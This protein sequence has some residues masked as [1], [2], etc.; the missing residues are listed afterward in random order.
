MRSPSI[1][2]R[3]T[4]PGPGALSRVT[5]AHFPATPRPTVCRCGL[6]RRTAWA[7]VLL[8]QRLHPPGGPSRR[9]A[10]RGGPRQALA[11]AGIASIEGGVYTVTP[12]FGVIGPIRESVAVLPPPRS[13]PCCCRVAR[14]LAGQLV[15]HDS[16]WRPRKPRLAKHW[17]VGWRSTA[18]VILGARL[19][20]GVAW[21][22]CGPSSA[23]RA[24][25]RTAAGAAVDQPDAG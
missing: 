21:Q 23:G 19:C 20:R 12:P 18:A 22:M 9:L 17:K 8:R 24:G 11:P 13:E 7:S 14:P 4:P 3:I 15:G 2:R 5:F 1:A 16:G 6:S 25:A 10:V